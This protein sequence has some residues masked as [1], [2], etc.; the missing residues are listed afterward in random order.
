MSED[1][2]IPLWKLRKGYSL[3]KKLGFNFTKSG[4]RNSSDDPPTPPPTWTPVGPFTPYSTPTPETLW[5]AN[6]TATSIP[7]RDCITV[8]LGNSD[9]TRWNVRW[10]YLDAHQTYNVI[11]DT[12]GIVGDGALLIPGLE[13]LDGGV[14]L[15]EIANIGI[16]TGWNTVDY[17]I[18]VF[19]KGKDP[20]QSSGELQ[21]NL[22]ELQA[23]NTQIAL[24][25]AG[26]TIPGAGSILNFA[27]L[28]KIQQETNF[29]KIYT[30]PVPNTLEV[31]R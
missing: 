12:A 26:K 13:E 20:L 10:D 6:P 29:I 4:S 19:V 11:A 14:T 16:D 17:L 3:L 25:R 27:D 5:V 9:E 24:S 7:S 18:D 21:F 22:A 30:V 31:C 8:F 23:T 28:Y 2:N 15:F 1:T